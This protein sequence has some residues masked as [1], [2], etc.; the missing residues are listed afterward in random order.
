MSPA[1]L[2]KVIRRIGAGHHLHAGE[3]DGLVS[4][5]GQAHGNAEVL[6]CLVRTY[7]KLADGCQREMSRAVRMALWEYK[8]GARA[9][10]V[11]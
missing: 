5:Q 8:K 6:K 9:D 1:C 2:P 11:V 10:W 7:S 3:S 4:S